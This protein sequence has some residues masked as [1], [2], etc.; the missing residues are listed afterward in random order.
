MPV[1]IFHNDFIGILFN[2]IPYLLKIVKNQIVYPWG[3]YP[4]ERWC[5]DNLLFRL[6]R[7]GEIAK[8]WA[9]HGIN[10][11]GLSRFYGFF[12]FSCFF[13]LKRASLFRK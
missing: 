8:N 4:W 11:S 5:K 13:C 3:R 7:P 6:S 1:T 9:S 10:L 12:G 2:F